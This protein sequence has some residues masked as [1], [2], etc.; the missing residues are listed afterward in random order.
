MMIYYCFIFAIL[1][2]LTLSVILA[3]TSRLSANAED[4]DESLRYRKFLPRPN[5]ISHYFMMANDKTTE[6]FTHGLDRTG[7]GYGN[8]Y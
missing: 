2:M 8:I 1:L 4:I 5:E 6:Y 3:N 7:S